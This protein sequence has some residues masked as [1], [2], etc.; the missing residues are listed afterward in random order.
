M[1]VNPINRIHQQ[2]VIYD[3]E[4]DRARQMEEMQHKMMM[5]ERMQHERYLQQAREMQVPQWWRK[6]MSGQ[7]TGEVLVRC[8]KSDDGMMNKTLRRNSYK[9]VMKNGELVE[10]ENGHLIVTTH[11]IQAYMDNDSPLD[12]SMKTW[13]SQTNTSQSKTVSGCTNNPQP[14]QEVGSISATA[15]NLVKAPPASPNHP[16]KSEELSES[17]SAAVSKIIKLLPKIAPKSAPEIAVPHKDEVL[18]ELKNPGTAESSQPMESSKDDIKAMF[19]MLKTTNTGSLVLWNFLWALLQDEKH[20]KIV[21]WI[22]FQE[23]KFRIVSPDMLATFWGKVKEN[24]SMDWQKIKKILDLYQRKSLLR[25]GVTDQEFTFLIVPK[26]V[27]ENL[28]SV[29]V[30]KEPDDSM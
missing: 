22:S 25:S 13:A 23:L 19:P 17:P 27:K 2:Q 15:I 18:K 6:S 12:L 26:T 1:Q 24:P 10:A 16:I 29:K 4:M 9:A 3:M 7:G 21:T 5:E 8:V 14:N 20:S 28:D 30:K 11:N